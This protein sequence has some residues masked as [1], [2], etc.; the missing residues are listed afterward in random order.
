MKNIIIIVT[1]MVFLACNADN[2]N[3]TIS[4]LNGTI[5]SEEDKYTNSID[6]I[7][8]TPTTIKKK[9]IFYDDNDT[10]SC[11][12]PYYLTDTICSRFDTN[13]VGISNRGSHI[14]YRDNYGVVFSKEII[15][16]NEDSLVLFWKAQK[17]FIGG[18]DHTTVLKRMK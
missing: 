15:K 3:F 18:R 9:I 1:T 13:K 11:Q 12:W 10:V 5:W 14:T 7:E 16:L 8:F 4:M 6:I 2:N 17:E